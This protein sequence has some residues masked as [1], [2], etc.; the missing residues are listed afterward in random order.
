M[1]QKKICIITYAW[2]PRNSI[3]AHRPYSWAKYWSEAGHDVTVL[4]SKKYSYDAPL[5]L[6]LDALPNVTVCEIEYKSTSAR[7]AKFLKNPRFKAFVKK[8]FSKA[9]STLSTSTAKIHP[10]HAW[11]PAAT[12]HVATNDLKF[13]FIVSTY[14][15]VE[16]HLIACEMKKTQPN[17]IWV[18]DYRDLWSGNHLVNWT[19][20]ERA[21]QR[22]TEIE[23]V[24]KFSDATS[25][26]SD[27]LA[28]NLSDLHGKPTY[29][30]FNGFDID[31]D[32]LSK[33]LASKTVSTDQFFKIIYTGKIYPGHRD[34]TP[35]MEAIKQ[36]EE[37]GDIKKGQFK[38]HFYGDKVN[39]SLPS[40]FSEH[41]SEYFES[42]GHVSR[43]KA[44]QAQNEA[45]ILLM[46]ES[47]DPQAKGVLTGKL[48]E[49]ISSGT[50]ILSLGSPKESAIAKL[51]CETKTGLCCEKDIAKIMSALKSFS[52]SQTF[53]G[54]EPE[55]FS[56]QKY[57]RKNQANNFLND[58]LKISG[59]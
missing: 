37:S 15:P 11:F 35:L 55:L 53:P 25:S 49:Y 2:P 20:Q 45:D 13:D 23:T 52:S 9:S 6:N 27:L 28:E 18:A 46:L 21:K 26:I 39:E 57:S 29:T 8:I 3:G 7:V 17:A 42:H 5:D 33:N 54:F 16:T 51:I 59:A 14:D 31:D 41:Y 32:H 40:S 47:S 38:V 36:G 58:I 30:V 1:K 48:F 12:K 19:D 43:T 4:T 34:P 24:G 44:L 50:P 10:R 56:I 22:Q